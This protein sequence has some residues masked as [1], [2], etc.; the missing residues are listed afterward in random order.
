MYLELKYKCLLCSSHLRHFELKATKHGL[1]FAP[2]H[3]IVVGDDPAVVHGKP[4]AN[5]FCIAAQ[6]FEMSLLPATLSFWI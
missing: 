2:M 3:H 4:S 1:I 5:I 6:R